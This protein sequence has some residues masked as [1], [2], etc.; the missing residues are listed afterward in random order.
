MG[1]C[2]ISAAHAAPFPNL[3]L[4]L[5][6]ATT[7]REKKK[8]E[9]NE[10]SNQQERN[11]PA[12]KQELS[13]CSGCADKKKHAESDGHLLPHHTIENIFHEAHGGG[14]G[15]VNW[16]HDGVV[17]GYNLDVSHLRE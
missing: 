7:G 17:H 15:G 2:N 14:G 11:S 6:D 5:Y 4:L 13:C 3:Q 1:F 10:K 9:Q 16:P 12:T 8:L